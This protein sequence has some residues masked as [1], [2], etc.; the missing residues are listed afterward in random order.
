[1]QK[2]GA[3]RREGRRAAG[4]GGGG[5]GGVHYSPIQ[6]FAEPSCAGKDAVEPICAREVLS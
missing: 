1:M 2:L 3:L 4:G 6:G 5:G